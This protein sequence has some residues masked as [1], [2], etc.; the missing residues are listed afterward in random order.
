MS[1]HTPGPWPVLRRRSGSITSIGPCV[2]DEYAGIAWLDV[3]EADAILMAAS[4]DLLEALEDAVNWFRQLKDWCGVGDPN[5]E[6]YQAA[7]AKAKGE[8]SA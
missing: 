8:Q 3:G 6:K 5:I 4:P 1:K 7:I 2:A